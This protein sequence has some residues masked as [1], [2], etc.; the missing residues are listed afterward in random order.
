MLAHQFSKNRKDSAKCNICGKECK[1]SKDHVFPKAL[2]SF[3]NGAIDNLHF[4]QRYDNSLPQKNNGVFFRTIC[5]EC[6]N[7]LGSNYDNHLVTFL[8]LLRKQVNTILN[9]INMNYLFPDYSVSETIC[10]SDISRAVIGHLL[11]SRIAYNGPMMDDMRSYLCAPE[12]SL[13]SNYH[14]YSWLF[15]ED[16]YSVSTEICIVNMN[17]DHIIYDCYKAYPLGFL[18]TN[19][20]WTLDG[21]IDLLSYPNDAEANLKYDCMK[22]PNPDWPEIGLNLPPGCSRIGGLNLMNS[23]KYVKR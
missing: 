16:E 21:S 3:R 6:N 11:S 10:P 19:Y 7:Y 20:D 23:L 4:F 14:L 13:P 9:L 1:L 22:H 17:L 18:F 15:L 5:R 12:S 8:C 2:L